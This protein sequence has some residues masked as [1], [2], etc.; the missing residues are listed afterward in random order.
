MDKLKKVIEQYGRWSELSLYTGRIES[1][2]ATDFSHALENVNAL[3]ESIGKEICAQK[4]FALESTASFG[5]I[6]K[7]AFTAIGYS[8]ESYVTQISTALANIAQQVGELRND[9]GPTSHGRSLDELRERNQMIDELTKDFLI[10]STVIVACFLI[11]TFENENPRNATAIAEKLQLSEQE[12]FNNF[13]DET[14]G[15]FEIGDYSYTASEIL[16]SVDYPAYETE[17]K[18]FTEVEEGDE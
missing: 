4:G 14:Y 17:C 13:L 1:S 2:L 8:G 15:E 3:L 16:Y 10:D 12:D 7:K 9:I 5:S 6:I 18:A 11:R